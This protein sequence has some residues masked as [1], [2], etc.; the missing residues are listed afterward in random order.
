MHDSEVLLLGAVGVSTVG[1]PSGNGIDNFPVASSFISPGRVL[2]TWRVVP[3]WPM[4]WS[5]VVPGPLRIIVSPL[6]GLVPLG[7]VSC[8]GHPGRSVVGVQLG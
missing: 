7:T 2:S 5:A 6:C 8:L 3:P 4:L 1:K